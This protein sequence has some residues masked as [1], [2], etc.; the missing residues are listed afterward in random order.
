MYA[1]D[2]KQRIEEKEGIRLLPDIHGCQ[3]YEATD[4]P[5]RFFRFDARA[6]VGRSLKNFIQVFQQASVEA[7]PAEERHITALEVLNAAKFEQ[8]GRARLLAAMTAI[9][10]LAEQADRSRQEK[11]V[12]DRLV[13][14]IRISGLSGQSVES[15]IDGVQRL[16]NESIGSACRG[17]VNRTLGANGK[18][19]FG[20][21]YTLRGKVTHGGAAPASIG[22]DA[23]KAVQ[24]ARQLVL[25]L[26]MPSLA[27]GGSSPS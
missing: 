20:D 13:S 22:S 7:V 8:S 17:L 14:A 27:S 23:E 15:L 12:I 10:V 1:S 16:K 26:L 6:T 18:S 4:R 5:T 3:V 11:D 21:L 19:L 25:A 9:E 24:L 2:F